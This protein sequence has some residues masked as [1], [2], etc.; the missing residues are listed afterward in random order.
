VETFSTLRWCGS[1]IRLAVDNV[2]NV[3]WNEAQFASTSR[4]R[5]EPTPVTELHY[6][7]GALRTVTLGIEKQF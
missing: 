6:T 4:L 3:R 7:P 5:G 1:T 2:F